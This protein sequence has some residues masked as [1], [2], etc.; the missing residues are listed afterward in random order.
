MKRRFRPNCPLSPLGGG[1]ERPCGALKRAATLAGDKE[2][3]ALF[4]NGFATQGEGDEPTKQILS[5]VS[6]KDFFRAKQL[7]GN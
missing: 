3:F 5:L 2:E 6:P 7:F 1:G 4:A